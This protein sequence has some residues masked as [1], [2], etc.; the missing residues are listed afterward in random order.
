MCSTAGAVLHTGMSSA[1]AVFRQPS[2]NSVSGSATS[3]SR[4]KSDV[5][6]NCFVLH[7]YV[8]AI[9]NKFPAVTG[10]LLRG[11]CIIVT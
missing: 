6:N 10:L 11:G 4:R 9:S 1:S 3:L 7:I 8:I 5:N 2:L